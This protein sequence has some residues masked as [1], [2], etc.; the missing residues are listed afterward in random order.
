MKSK[1]DTNL[2]KLTKPLCLW[3]NWAPNSLGAQ[4]STSENQTVGP[5]LDMLLCGW[6]PS[7]KPIQIELRSWRCELAVGRTVPHNARYP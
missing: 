5:I 4:L 1:A 7:W 2:L 3:A 6:T